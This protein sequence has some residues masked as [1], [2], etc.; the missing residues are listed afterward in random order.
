MA[1]YESLAHLS[2]WRRLVIWF[3]EDRVGRNLTAVVAM[4]IM[5]GPM[6]WFGWWWM[7][8]DAAL[9]IGFAFGYNTARW[10]ASRGEVPPR[11]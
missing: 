7:V 4:A 3:C 11:L 5:L 1:D 2:R 10:W 9:W 6:Y 8:V